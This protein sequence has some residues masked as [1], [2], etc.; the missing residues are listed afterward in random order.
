MA[1]PVLTLICTLLISATLLFPAFAA[2]ITR[3]PSKADSS[4]GLSITS[5][6][7]GYFFA[8]SEQRN[9]TTSYGVK[10]GYEKIEKAVAGSLGIEGTLNYFSTG[11]KLGGGN[12]TGYLYRLDAIYPFPINKKWLPFIAVGVGGITIDAPANTNSNFLFNYGVGVKY[13]LENYLALRADARQLIIYDG[14]VIRNNYEIGL[15]LSYYFG[16]ERVKKPTPRPVPEKKKIFVL[17]DEPVKNEEAA[18]PAETEAADKA[19]AGQP[20]PLAVEASVSLVVKNEVVK[21]FSVEFDSNSSKIKPHY[22]GQLK[23]IRDILKRSDDVV[24][25]IEGHTDVKGNLAANIVLSEQRAQSVR[26]SLIKSGV[27]PKQLSIT[28]YGPAKPIADN[29]TI[30]G[31]QKN[32]RVDI[33]VEKINPAV[34]IKAEQELQNAADRIENARLAAEIFTKSRIKAAIVL[35]EVSGSLPV[36]TDQ[37]LSFEMVNQGLSTEEYL[38]TI[39]APKEFDA[40]LT[41]ANRPV[42]KVTILRLAPGETFKGSVLFRIPAGMVDGHRATI[43]VKAVSPKFSDVFFQ[44]ESLVVCSAPLVRVVAKLSKQ[45]VTPGEKLHYRLSLLNAGSL[46]A[47]NLTVKLQLPPQVDVTGTPDVPFTQDAAGMVVFKVD[48]IDSGKRTEINIDMKVREESV[49][50]QELLWH[51]EVIEGTLQRRAKSTERASVVP[52]K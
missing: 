45:Q 27:N 33:Q 34:K 42:E 52:P 35:Q 43:S 4:G 12:D 30:E 25:L 47:R 13:Y 17:E 38:V 20:V 44:K 18:K 40:F 7:G 10:V 28:A 2:E 26:S 31:R 50:G 29:T 21:K 24:A 1:K 16:K 5:T 41:R 51:V 9:A 15:G 6:I 32:R 23:E 48:A 8:G 3:P 14:S 22:Y 49:V 46:P 11:S 36:D 19:A 37:S 39:T